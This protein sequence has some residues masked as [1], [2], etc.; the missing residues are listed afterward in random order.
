MSMLELPPLTSKSQTSLIL[1]LGSLV[2]EMKK[3]P[4]QPP[5]ALSI[6]Q[7][8]ATRTAPNYDSS[9]SSTSK[10]HSSKDGAVM[11]VKR[12][13]TMNNLHHD[14]TGKLDTL[15]EQRNNGRSPRRAMA[16]TI[17]TQRLSNRSEYGSTTTGATSNKPMSTSNGTTSIATKRCVSSIDLTKT[18]RNNNHNN[19]QNANNNKGGSII[20]RAGATLPRHRSEQKLSDLSLARPT[21]MTKSNEML[22][23]VNALRK[24]SKSSEGER[25]RG[26]T[27]SAEFAAL[28]RADECESDD[29]RA[30]RILAWLH[31]VEKFA[32]PPPEVDSED[33]DDEVPPQTDTA[34]HIVYEGGS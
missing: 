14:A 3:T 33:L 17:S 29:D 7:V 24:A 23:N 4:K 15:F 20:K 1:G 5:A 32:E 11:L 34:I 18:D 16:R 8:N 10:S 30:E 19:S 31:N 6:V 22:D 26:L 21:T 25:E 12:S 28:G 9:A 2:E 27:K 13:K